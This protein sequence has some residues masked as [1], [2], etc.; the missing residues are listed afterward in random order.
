MRKPGLG[1][2]DTLLNGPCPSP[3]LKPE[4]LSSTHS[5]SG[6]FRPCQS[7]HP[8]DQVLSHHSKPR[9]GHL[10]VLSAVDT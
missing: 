3:G 10:C 4:W 5:R 1:V 7:A 2:E 6:S 8:R 9:H